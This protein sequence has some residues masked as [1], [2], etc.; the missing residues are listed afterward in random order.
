[1]IFFVFLSEFVE[2]KQGMPQ[3]T[4]NTIRHTSV[5]HCASLDKVNLG[6][7]QMYIIFPAI[8]SIGH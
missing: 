3:A 7:N 2:F 1:M 5:K 6:T 8:T 4:Q